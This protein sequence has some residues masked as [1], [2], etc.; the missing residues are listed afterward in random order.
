ML[1]R[2]RGISEVSGQPIGER[3]HELRHA[4]VIG[5]LEHRLV[6]RR[7]LISRSRPHGPLYAPNHRDAANVVPSR[8]VLDWPQSD[9]VYP[10]DKRAASR[11]YAARQSSG[12]LSR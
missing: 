6:Y 4:S 7:S 5:F 10:H 8:A 2:L 1:N 3:L 11:R 12:K 9:V